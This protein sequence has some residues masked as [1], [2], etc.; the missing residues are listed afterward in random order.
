MLLLFNVKPKKERTKK[1]PYRHDR[2]IVLLYTPIVQALAPYHVDRLP[3]VAGLV[4][5]ALFIG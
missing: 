1:R 2:G 3:A 4:P 5:H